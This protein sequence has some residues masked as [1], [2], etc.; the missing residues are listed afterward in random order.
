ML[1]IPRENITAVSPDDDL[2]DAPQGQQLA[3]EERHLAARSRTARR[4]DKDDREERGHQALSIADIGDA[5]DHAV[6][7]FRYEERPVDIRG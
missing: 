7:V 2:D 5:T 1:R 6:A 3:H 4:D